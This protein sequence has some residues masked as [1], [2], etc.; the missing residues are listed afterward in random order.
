MLM[1]VVGVVGIVDTSHAHSRCWVTL[2]VSHTQDLI[3]T[4]TRSERKV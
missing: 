2:R 4:E 3:T 1:G